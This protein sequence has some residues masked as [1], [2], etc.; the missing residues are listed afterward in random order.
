VSFA[1]GIRPK[2]KAG[3]VQPRCFA[4]HAIAAGSRRR[5]ERHHRQPHAAITELLAQPRSV[6]SISLLRFIERTGSVPAGSH[7]FTVTTYDLTAGKG[8]VLLT[9]LLQFCVF[10]TSEVLTECWLLSFT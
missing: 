3:V 4:E 5:R 10:R 8:D 1:I 2:A 6:G 9:V 7:V